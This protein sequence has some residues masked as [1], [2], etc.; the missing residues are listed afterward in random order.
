M[1]KQSIDNAAV[2]KTACVLLGAFVIIGVFSQHDGDVKTAHADDNTS[3][4]HGVTSQENHPSGSL[5]ITDPVTISKAFLACKNLDDLD[6][7]KKLALVDQD[8]KAAVKYGFSHGCELQQ[9]GKAFIIQDFAPFHG[10]TCIRLSGDPDCVWYPS[11]LL[12]KAD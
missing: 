9:P 5:R 10:A 7:V 11:S 6:R 3:G 4:K 12:V 8:A 2:V 1:S